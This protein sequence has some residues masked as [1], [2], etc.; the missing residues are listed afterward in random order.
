MA[1]GKRILK[2]ILKE[3]EKF[4]DKWERE[5]FLEMMILQH[6]ELAEELGKL[7]EE[8]EKR[9]VEPIPVP[10]ERPLEALPMLIERPEETREGLET[11]VS[12]GEERVEVEGM[13]ILDYGEAPPI[14]E[15]YMRKPEVRMEWKPSEETWR[16]PEIR[17]EIRMEREEFGERWRGFW[18][19][20]LISDEDVIKKIREYERRPPH[21][22]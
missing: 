6:P 7:R 14:D 9:P 5:A 10:E 16:E 2:E 19:E 11:R 15:E 3:L 17:E 4:E 12:E 22:R 20:K 21:E 13:R 8:P 1:G 18:E